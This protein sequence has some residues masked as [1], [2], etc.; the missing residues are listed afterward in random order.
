MFNLSVTDQFTVSEESVVGLYSNH[1]ALL[2]R[3]DTD[4]VIIIYEDNGNQSSIN[5]ADP[6][7]NENINFNISIRV[8]L[9]KQPVIH[10][11]LLNDTATGM[12]RVN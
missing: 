1:G 8:H 10:I 9:G 11:D 4:D 6:D 5:K 3:T 2:L 7:K 12:S